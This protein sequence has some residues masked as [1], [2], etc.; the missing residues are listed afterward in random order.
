[1]KTFSFGRD[2]TVGEGELGSRVY[3]G[4]S[5]FLVSGMEGLSSIYSCPGF[6]ILY[7]IFLFILCFIYLFIIF[8]GVVLC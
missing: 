2:F 4:Y 8:C 7:F 3:P 6:F 1:V 5:I